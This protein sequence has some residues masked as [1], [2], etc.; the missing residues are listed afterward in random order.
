[1]KYLS[2]K[3]SQKWLEEHGKKISDKTLRKY[4][5]EKKITAIWDFDAKYGNRYMIEVASLA[6]LVSPVNFQG[7]DETLPEVVPSPRAMEL[8]VEGLEKALEAL[9]NRIVERVEARLAERDR[10]LDEFIG[11]WREK[12]KRPWWAFWKR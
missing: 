12:K 3:G 8:T 2:I 6:G 4:I 9:E 1:M 7:T 11:E 5:R 10:R